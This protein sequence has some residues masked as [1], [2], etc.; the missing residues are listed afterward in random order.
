MTPR[1]PIPTSTYPDG[2]K[3]VGPTQRVWATNTNNMPVN[4][5][6]IVLYVTTPPAGMAL[7]VTATVS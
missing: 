1:S 5:G 4:A 2:E 3:T 7:A 6:H